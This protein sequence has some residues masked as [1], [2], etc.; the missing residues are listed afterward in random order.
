MIDLCVCASVN[1]AS[2]IDDR[3]VCVPVNV[4]AGRE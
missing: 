1:V 4:A 2:S 3:V